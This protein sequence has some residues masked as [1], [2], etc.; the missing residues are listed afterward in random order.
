MGGRKTAEI[1]LLEF[2]ERPPFASVF[3]HR[4]RC[5]DDDYRYSE[6]TTIEPS[7]LDAEVEEQCVKLT[8]NLGLVFAGIDLRRS[9]DGTWYCFEVNP[10][11]GFTY[12]DHGTGNISLELAKLLA[13]AS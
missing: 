1:T 12:F 11:P 2:K 9:V 4:I 10:S 3:T 8:R 7:K 6:R 13:A 5:E